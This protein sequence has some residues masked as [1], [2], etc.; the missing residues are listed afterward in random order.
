[1]SLSLPSATLFEN[2]WSQAKRHLRRY[3]G[4]P[5][6]HVH[7]FLKKSEWRFNGGSP[8]DLLRSLKQWG[9]LRSQGNI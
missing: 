1:M 5:R 9:K 8:S 6:Q 3:N 2:F 7:L 4:I